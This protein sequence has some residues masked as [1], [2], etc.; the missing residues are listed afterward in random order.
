MAK[1][2][3]FFILVWAVGIIY[4]ATMQGSGGVVVT[5]VAAIVAEADVSVTVDSIAGFPPESTPG[6]VIPATQRVIW[7]DG[8]QIYYD[9]LDTA[10]PRFTGLTRG[11]A[12]GESASDHAIDAKV[13]STVAW[14]M[15]STGDYEIVNLADTAGSWSAVTTPWGVITNIGTFIVLPLTFAGT[16]LA[17]LTYV[18]SALGAG[19]LL[20]LGLSLAGGRRV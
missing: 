6:N 7:I 2:T 11:S 8:E 19:Y 20:A 13:Y 3:T 15:N 12:D 5:E 17:L 16:D 10:P 18:Y 9:A 14:L 4:G 1:M